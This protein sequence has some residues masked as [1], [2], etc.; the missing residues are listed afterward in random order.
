M[1]PLRQLV[2]DFLAASKLDPSEGIDGSGDLPGTTYRE[3]S[4]SSSLFPPINI[5]CGFWLVLV[6]LT[7][8]PLFIFPAGLLISLLGGLCKS[9][10]ILG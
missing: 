1:D 3:I 6:S 8:L 5:I 4:P 7:F 10:C 2:V 9:I